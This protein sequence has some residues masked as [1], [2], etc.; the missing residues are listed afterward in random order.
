MLSNDDDAQ[1]VAQ[2]AFKR[3][4]IQLRS[5]TAPDP[6]SAHAV[7]AWLYR[8]A[9]RL[10][11]DT[12]R[13]QTVAKRWVA[14][15]VPDVPSSLSDQVIAGDLFA[16]VATGSNQTL[17]PARAAVSPSAPEPYSCRHDRSAR[18]TGGAT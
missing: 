18:S 15:S 9:T 2:E 13:H 8:T 16:Q 4:C 10:A 11:I 3:L 6:A 5:H 12:L 14:A 1:G 7:M 17:P